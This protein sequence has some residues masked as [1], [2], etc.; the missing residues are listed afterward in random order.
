VFTTMRRKRRSEMMKRELGQSVD[1]FKRAAALAAQETSATVGPK[2]SAARDRVQPAAVKAKDAASSGWGSTV[3]TLAPLITAASENVRHAGKKSEQVSKKEAKANKKNAKKLEKRA[4]KALGH[5]QSG[6]RTG[7]FFGLALAGAAVGAGAAYLA[8]KRKA[9][10]WDEYDPGRPIESTGTTTASTVVTEPAV[11]TTGA[12]DTAFEPSETST[13]ATYSEPAATASTT[14]VTETETPATPAT[15]TTSDEP[16]VVPD[17]DQTAS[18]QH[19]PK[20]AKMASGQNTK[21]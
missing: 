1:H 13:T 18:A 5:K 14:V 9:A 7:K 6:R 16:M 2:V 4:N 20:V 3:A 19:S 21:D 8:R 11:T 12:E 17:G 15:G 10:Q